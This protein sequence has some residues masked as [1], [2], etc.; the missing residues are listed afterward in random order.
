MENKQPHVKGWH[1]N[2]WRTKITE[3]RRE[4]KWIWQAYWITCVPESTQH[5]KEWLRRGLHAP[6]WSCNGE[7]LVRVADP[8]YK[9]KG[10]ASQCSW[11]ETCLATKGARLLSKI[12]QRASEVAQ[13]LR[14]VWF[15]IPWWKGKDGSF[16]FSFDFLMHTLVYAHTR[17][18]K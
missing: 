4:N 10:Q 3:K 8:V 15:L 11:R 2:L 6:A 16:K 5:F 17:I 18:C 1:R 7:V 12:S 9:P 14:W 13:L